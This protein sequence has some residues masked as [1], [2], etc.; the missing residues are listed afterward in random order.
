M[1]KPA[2]AV[3]GL[4]VARS[5]KPAAPDQVSVGVVTESVTPGKLGCALTNAWISWSSCA[6]SGA[7]LVPV[8]AGAACALTAAESRSAASENA[9]ASRVRIRW[10]R[11]GFMEVLLWLGVRWP[12][13]VA[14]R[15]RERDAA[16]RAA[17][18]DD[19]PSSVHAAIGA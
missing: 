18:L 16:R 13:R 10:R 11:L 4:R 3:S 17:P 6:G 9:A 15:E 19:H 7:A 8:G 12:E 2:A 1:R 5:A 14:A